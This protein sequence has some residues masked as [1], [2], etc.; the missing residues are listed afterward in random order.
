MPPDFSR[1]LP[2]QAIDH[3]ATYTDG[4]FKVLLHF[5]E[6]DSKWHSH[7]CV[8]LPKP[9]STEPLHYNPNV[10]CGQSIKDSREMARIW[11]V[12]SA[13]QAVATLEQRLTNK[14]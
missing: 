2:S 8:Y 14:F 10:L 5:D 11:A 4:D 3:F 6:V 1:K 12:D 9:D 13:I 7:F